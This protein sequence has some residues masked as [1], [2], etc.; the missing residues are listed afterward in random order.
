V[1]VL[2][3][4]SD[5]VFDVRDGAPVDLAVAAAD[6][7]APDLSASDLAV[8]DLAMLDLATVDSLMQMPPDT[9]GGLDPACACM[10]DFLAQLAACCP[11]TG[12][13][14]SGTDKRCF[15][16]C[17]V[18]ISSSITG[19]TLYRDFV[20]SS[21]CASTSFS[22]ASVQPI[23]QWSFSGFSH[24]V[25]ASHNSMPFSGSPSDVITCDGHYAAGTV[26]DAAT[27]LDGWL[28]PPCPADSSCK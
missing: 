28:T 4:C 27:A 12:S 17:T 25:M 5:D 22:P 3:A 21:W 8:A 24:T 19:S 6:L 14:S 20:G 10:A 16:A 18:M 2:A 9:D 26:C 1:C 15:A 23:D 7:A 13:C 11:S